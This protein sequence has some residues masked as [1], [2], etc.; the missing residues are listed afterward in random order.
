MKIQKSLENLQPNLAV[1]RWLYVRK[2]Q[3]RAVLFFFEFS[4]HQSLQAT[5]KF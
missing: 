5:C 2:K 1:R 4:H 3:S